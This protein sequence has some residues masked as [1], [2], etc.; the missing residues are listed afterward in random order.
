[1]TRYERAGLHDEIVHSHD[2]GWSEQRGIGDVELEIRRRADKI[3]SFAATLSD[4]HTLFPHEIPGIDNIMLGTVEDALN[5]GLLPDESV[6]MLVDVRGAAFYD[7]TGTYPIEPSR[8]AKILPI[9]SQIL[10]PG[11][12]MLL[13][14]WA[15]DPQYRGLGEREAR[16][17]RAE[18]AALLG[19]LDRYNLDVERN[20]GTYAL[21]RKHR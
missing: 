5:K 18:N 2:L 19:Y 3:F 13:F 7:G 11:G 15:F 14:E 20:M 21:L 10:K 1:M 4:L 12:N 16:V 9:Y 6:H 17:S 8:G